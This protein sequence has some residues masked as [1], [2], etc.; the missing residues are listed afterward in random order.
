MIRKIALFGLLAATAC[1]SNKSYDDQVYGYNHRGYDHHG[2]EHAENV[3]AN[4]EM[5]REFI[6]KA[7]SAGMFEVES[8]RLVLSRQ[9]PD[10]ATDFAQ[11]MIRD[12]SEANERLKSIADSKNVPLPDQMSPEDMRKIARL[13]SLQGDQFTDV[14]EQLQLD[15]HREAVQLFDRC[16]KFC[17]DPEIREFAEQTL[18]TLR[19][20]L[21]HVEGLEARAEREH[22][23]HRPYG[24][25]YRD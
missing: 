12:H 24:Q 14:Y 4:L 21:Q 22:R 3:P 7:A 17:Q 23:P 13:R 9:A 16:S 18:P 19:Q 10:D 15:A 8:S 2:K 25:P 20:H 11:T 1:A 5:D 6:D